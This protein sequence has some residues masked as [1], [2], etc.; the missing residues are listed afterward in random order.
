MDYHESDGSTPAVLQVTGFVAAAPETVWRCFTNAAAITSW[1]SPEATA[2]AHVGG[3]IVAAWPDMGWTM[4]GAYTELVENQV[5]AFT[6]SWQHEPDRPERHVRVHLAPQDDGTLVTLSHG[7]YAAHEADE[8]TSHLE[9]WL[10]FLPK[11][12]DAADG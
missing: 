7:T 6:W 8:R 2:E 9:G 11:L 12:A 4:R 1:W 5:V 3:P 10:H